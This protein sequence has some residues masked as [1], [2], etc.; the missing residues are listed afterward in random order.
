MTSTPTSPTGPRWRALVAGG[1]TVAVVGLVVAA[2]AVWPGFDAQETPLQDSSVWA[3]QTGDG[4]NYARV[5]TALGELVT[6]KQ[7]ENPSRLAQT[8]G[9][10]FVFTDGDSKY[11][12]VSLPSPPD[13]DADAAIRDITGSIFGIAYQWVVLPEHHDLAHEIAS[14]RARIIAAYAA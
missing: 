1:A 11:A 7:V 13:I 9:H 14:V 12:D 10:L 8:Q 3:L 5:N 6:V 4:R 2:A